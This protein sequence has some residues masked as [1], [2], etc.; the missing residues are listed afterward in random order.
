MGAS[1]VILFIIPNSPLAQPWPFPGGQLI[2]IIYWCCL[3]P[4]SH[5][6]GTSI[7]FGGRR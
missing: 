2:S 7:G 5:C 3:L 6:Y 4:I 1:T